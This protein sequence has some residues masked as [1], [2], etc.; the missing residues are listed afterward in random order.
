MEENRETIG[1]TN[2]VVRSGPPLLR[3]VLVALIV[4]SI[5]AVS[6]L[7]LVNAGIRAQTRQMQSE[8]AALQSENEKLKG[9]ISSLGTPESIRDIAREELGLVDP[10][11]VIINP[12]S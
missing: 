2:V 1:R 6:A 9:Q 5:T 7:I 4:L 11:T 3:I 8:I 10:N 12:N